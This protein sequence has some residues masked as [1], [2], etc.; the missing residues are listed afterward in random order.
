MDEQARIMQALGGV[1][2]AGHSV[3]GGMGLQ[4]PHGHDGTDDGRKQDIGDILHQIMTITDQSLDEA[5]AKNRKHGLNCHRMKPALF[6]VLC[7]IKEK[8]GLSIR[9]SQEEDPPDPQLMRLDNMLLAEGVSGPEK[10]GGSAAAAAAA[11][12]SG[13]ASDNSIE[14]SDYRSKLTQI[15]QIYHTELEKYEQAC[16]EFTTHVMNLLREQSRTRPISPKEIERMV[17][18]IHRKFSSIQMQLKQST[19]EAVMILRSRFLDAR[20][21]RRNFSKQATE[22]LNEYFYSH[23][24]NPYPSEEAKEELAKKCSITVSQV[25]NWFGNK[26]IRYKKN[27]GK[28]QEEANLYA[29]KTAVTAAHAVAAAVQNSQTNSPTT[30][31][32]GFQMKDEEFQ[33]DSA[34]SKNTLLTNMFT[35]SSGSFNLP[36]SGDMFL[37]MQSLNGDSYQGAQV[38][39]NVQSQVDTLRHV[40]SQTAGYSEA[41]GGNTMYSP[42]GLNANGGWHD[43]MTPSSV[44]SPTEGPGS[45]HSDTSN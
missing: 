32:S 4:P 30:P 17:G 6:S 40:I 38:G 7:E 33:L 25:S 34:E 16:N 43:A 39:V 2:L 5:Q 42:N 14:H 19:C 22:I 44:I 15:R 20:R 23:L 29:A 31:N 18:I 41:L 28:F 10:G 27:I 3:Q 8:T 1:S 35:G 9:G 11:A 12:A 37:S 45:V 36:N 21:K 13:G 24:S 26:R